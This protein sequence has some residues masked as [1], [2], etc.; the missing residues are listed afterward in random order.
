MQFDNTRIYARS[1]ELI[2]VTH[3]IMQRF[4]RGYGFLVDQL[5]RAASS[6]PLNFAEGYGR[7]TQREQ[8]RF[9]VIARGSASE[10]AAILDVARRFDIVVESDYAHARDICDHLARMLTKFRRA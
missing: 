2:D 10:V 3:K 4:P 7:M 6:V 1:L 8:R 5:R 9:F